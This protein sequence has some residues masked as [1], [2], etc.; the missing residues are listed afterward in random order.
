MEIRANAFLLHMVRNIAGALL[1]VGR[2]ERTT[3]WIGELLARRDRTQGAITAPATGLYL[4][5]VRYPAE[6]GVPVFPPG[7]VFLGMAL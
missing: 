2:G 6:F 1:A 7:P 3:G 5:A 4:V